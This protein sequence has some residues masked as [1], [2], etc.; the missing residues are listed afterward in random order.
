[1]ILAL[2]LSFIPRQADCQKNKQRKRD[3][4]PTAPVLSVPAKQKDTSQLQATG[5]QQ[6]QADVRVIHT[7]G[8]DRYDIAAFWITV[9]L[10]VVGVSGIG[11]AL[12]TLRAVERQ[13]DLMEEQLEE[14]KTA[15]A[16]A[17]D[18]AGAAAKSAEAAL[19]QG[20]T[21]V[22]R[23]RARVFVRPSGDPGTPVTVD[24]RHGPLIGA[25]RFQFFNIGPTSAINLSIRY[26]AVATE[27]ATPSEID[28]GN[29]ALAEDVI[30]ANGTIDPSLPIQKFFGVTPDPIGFFIHVRGIAE[31]NDVLSQEI[32]TSKFLFS[33][34][35]R[36]ARGDGT[37]HSVG[38]WRKSGQPE[39]NRAS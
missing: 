1:M 22:E 6:I 21:M 35:M 37:A 25:H 32:R 18:A 12:K 36:Q 16:I 29:F 38:R 13:A 34:E 23:E 24:L 33:L 14:M 17:N 2:S 15:S 9:A 10:F 20:R 7:P 31:Y 5:G 11:A 3:Q 4:E 30:A 28:P 26:V 27:F 19:A 39:D 8:K